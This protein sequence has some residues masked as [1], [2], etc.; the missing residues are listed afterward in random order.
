[1][2]PL[3][4]M[5]CYYLAHFIDEPAIRCIPILS[6][7]GNGLHRGI[8]LFILFPAWIGPDYPFEMPTGPVPT[9]E[10]TFQESTRFD[11]S[12]NDSSDS[13]KTLISDTYG[14]GYLHLGPFKHRFHSAAH[15]S[16]HCLNIFASGT[17]HNDPFIHH[18][19]HCLMY[20]RQVFMCNADVTLEPGVSFTRNLTIDRLGVTRQCRDWK[21]VDAWMTKKFNEWLEF[22]GVS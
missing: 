16:L 3:F 11:L 7:V 4:S 18:W 19:D 13:W 12:Y 14:V 5:V 6:I 8:Q 2:H 15:H 17:R 10:M 22:N 20:M 1:M 21:A 9:V